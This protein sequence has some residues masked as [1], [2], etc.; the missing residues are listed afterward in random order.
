MPSCGTPKHSI[1][2][3]RIIIQIYK[4]LGGYIYENNKLEI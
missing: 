4:N 1:I 3:D 2:F